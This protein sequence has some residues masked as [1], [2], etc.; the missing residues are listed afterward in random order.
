MHFQFFFLV[1]LL[2]VLLLLLNAGCVC[3]CW[4]VRVSYTPAAVLLSG[5][6]DSTAVMHYRVQNATRVEVEEN[7]FSGIYS[8]S[9]PIGRG[10]VIT[11]WGLF[12]FRGGGWVLLPPI[13]PLV[14]H[15][16]LHLIYLQC[17][18]T[19]LSFLYNNPKC[20][21]SP[22]LFSTYIY[23][24]QKS[25]L[26]FLFLSPLKPYSLPVPTPFPRCTP[27]VSH[28]CLSV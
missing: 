17:F 19:P 8:V 25:P 3:V 22:P 18:Q 10:G 5:G 14:Q 24:L 9:A 26:P 16:H 15:T 7:R 20:K 11:F 1:V 27:A 12:I 4:S 21:K 23:S 6:S 28:C 2:S 13:N